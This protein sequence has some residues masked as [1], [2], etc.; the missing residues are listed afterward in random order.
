MS[1]EIGRYRH[2]K[3]NEYEVIGVAKHSEDETELVVYR[4]LYGDMRLWVRPLQMFIETV[5]VD[6]KTKPRFEHIS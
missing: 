2:Y 3:G 1:L 4:P 6:G 5:Q